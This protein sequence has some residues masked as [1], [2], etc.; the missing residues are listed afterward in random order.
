MEKYIEELRWIMS[1][2][3]NNSLIF[4]TLLLTANLRRRHD[5]PTPESPISSSLNKKSL[6]ME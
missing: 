2:S 4:E 3:Y 6:Q 5:F 1:F